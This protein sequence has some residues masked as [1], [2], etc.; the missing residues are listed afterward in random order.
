LEKGGY[1]YIMSNKNRTSLYIGVTATLYWRALEHKSGN[2]GVFTS[3]Y[4]CFD[5]IYFETFTSM[6]E[7]IAREKVLKKWNREWKIN[8][9]KKLNPNME[10]LTDSVKDY[11]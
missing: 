1:I 11:I 4:N 7:A 10:D 2:S 8:L 3:K 6:K 5:L 9:I